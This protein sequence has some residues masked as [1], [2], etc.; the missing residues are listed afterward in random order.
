MTKHTRDNFYSSFNRSGM[1]NR[2]TARLRAAIE[3]G[4]INSYRPVGKSTPFLGE[5]N[6]FFSNDQRIGFKS[7][8]LQY[9][10]A[11]VGWMFEILDGK[12]QALSEWLHSFRFKNPT[13]SDGLFQYLPMACVRFAELRRAEIIADDEFPKDITI[14][15]AL[16]IISAAHEAYHAFEYMDPS[17]ALAQDGMTAIMFGFDKAIGRIEG[18]MAGEEAALAIAEQLAFYKLQVNGGEICRL[19]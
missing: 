13:L 18:G 12:P 2:E 10:V 16:P 11:E 1:A 15:D 4:M 3:S 7:G 5:F 6:A 14:A 8:E 19:C 17:L 9:R